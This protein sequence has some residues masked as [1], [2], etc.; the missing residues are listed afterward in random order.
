MCAPM[1]SLMFFIKR[2]C[3]RIYTVNTEI[4]SRVTRISQII[5]ISVNMGTNVFL[6]CHLPLTVMLTFVLLA[7]AMELLATHL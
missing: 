2:R 7:D 6:R 4:R 1:M 5:L 3:N